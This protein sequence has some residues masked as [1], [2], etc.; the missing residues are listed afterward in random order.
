MLR[1]WLQRLR[2]SGVK[3]HVRHRWVGWNE[4]QQLLFAT[5]DGETSVTADAVLLAL[6]GGSWSRL[7][8]MAHGCLCYKPAISPW[9]RCRPPTVVL[10]WHGRMISVAALPE[11]R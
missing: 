11:R 5:P 9:H 2:E 8:L 4:Q 6:G 1:T 10:S 7:V 3:F